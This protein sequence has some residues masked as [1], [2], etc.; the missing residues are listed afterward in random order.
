MDRIDVRVIVDAPAA[1]EVALGVETTEESSAVV[2]ARVLE[3]RERQRQRYRGMP[4]SLNAQ[5][6]GPVLRREWPLPAHVAAHFNAQLREQDQ[7]SAR[8]I[9]RMLR[10]AWTCADLGGRDVPDQQDLALA[11]RLRDAGGRWKA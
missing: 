3:A 9:D 8:G 11:M 10:L 4:W 5:V 7:P 1:S 6:P 2:A